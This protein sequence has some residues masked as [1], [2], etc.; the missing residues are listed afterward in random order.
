MGRLEK[1]NRTTLQTPNSAH[2]HSC[3]GSRAGWGYTDRLRIHRK[4][5]VHGG[6][7]T[8]AGVEWGGVAFGLLLHGS[9][10]SVCAGE[11]H[12]RILL[13]IIAKCGRGVQRS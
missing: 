2:G 13:S 11:A 9:Y 5:P 3:D 12:L 10:P 7:L 1:G 8:S 4:S 6:G